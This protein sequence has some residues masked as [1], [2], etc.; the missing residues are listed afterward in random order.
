MSYI[1]EKFIEQKDFLEL[2][3]KNDK[4]ASDTFAQMYYAKLYKYFVLS[5]FD[6]HKSLDLIQETLC[7]FLSKL[8]SGDE[9]T[10][11]NAS[12]YLFKIAR[13]CAIDEFRREKKERKFLRN[14]LLE[15]YSQCIDN[16]SGKLKVLLNLIQ[17]LNSVEK[18][19]IILH[20]ILGKT[21]TEVSSILEISLSSCKRMFYRAFEKLRMWYFSKVKE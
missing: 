4:F 13:N 5:G 11:F 9:I 17:K 14:Y 1:P 20:L 16:D 19:I 6:T 8:K 3:K 10:I 2:L 7:K 12:S 15:L 21:F 18:N